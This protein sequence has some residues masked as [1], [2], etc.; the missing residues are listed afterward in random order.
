[1]GLFSIN[2]MKQAIIGQFEAIQ[3]CRHFDSSQLL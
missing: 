3:G 2:K 1:M